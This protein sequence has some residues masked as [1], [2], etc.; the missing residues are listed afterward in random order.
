MIISN[1]VCVK[2]LRNT[3]NNSLLKINR[4]KK[5]RQ[6]WIT[7]H[8]T[9]FP[10]PG[11]SQLLRNANITPL[12]QY[13]TLQI[14]SINGQLE[15]TRIALRLQAKPYFYPLKQSFFSFDLKRE[16][17]AMDNILQYLRIVSLLF[18]VSVNIKFYYVYG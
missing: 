7:S 14:S 18:R 16:K 4:D 9:R 8:S 5:G 13:A 3:R 15:S 10:I 1:P 6:E 12:R 17:R 2:L 11:L